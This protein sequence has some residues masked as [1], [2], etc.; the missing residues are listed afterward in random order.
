M[1]AFFSSRDLRNILR[2]LVAPLLISAFT[3]PASA[4]PT[5][6]PT[7]TVAGTVVSAVDNQ[8]LQHAS[9]ELLTTTDDRI[10]Q[11]TTSD[12]LGRFSFSAVAKGVFVLRGEAP[13]FLLTRYQQH[14][15]YSTGITTGSSVSTE[16]LTLKLQPLG[17]LSGTITDEN[18]EPVRNATVHLYRRTTVT[19]DAGFTP[20]AQLQTNDLG[21]Y[22]SA[23]L[24]PGT[25]FVAVI[26]R[27]WYAVHPAPA[28]PVPGFGGAGIVPY[29]D[30]ALDVAYPVTYYPAGTDPTA[31]APID[32][33]GN[34]ARADLQL[35][36][37]PALTLAVPRTASNSSAPVPQLQAGVFGHP[38]FTPFEVRS[39]SDSV[40]LMGVPPG[41]YTLRT[42]IPI[43]SGSAVQIQSSAATHL[44]L[45]PDGPNTLPTSLPS[46]AHIHVT[47]QAADGSP[48]PP[49][50][51]LRVVSSDV[52]DPTPGPFAPVRQAD[53]EA[54]PGNYYF[55][56]NMPR[57]VFVRSVLV[58]GKPLPS[59][60][61]HLAPGD[62]LT[63]TLLLT[64]STHVL[65]GVVRQ[66]AEPVS[67]AMLLLIPADNHLTLR[68]W[69]QAQSDLDGSFEI[70]S[71]PPGPYLLLALDEAAWSAHWRDP[72]FLSSHLPRASAVLV[73]DNSSGP[74][75]IP[76]P[77][78]LQPL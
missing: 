24:P 62:S 46:L 75:Q 35:T 22:Q 55:A 26:A 34:Q 31:A 58:S 54:A 61:I 49:N 64:L 10:L 74:I 9:V 1:H 51:Q 32:I 14:G 6:Q 53:L 60:D 36:P 12:E 11:S 40:V 5:T 76:Q 72:A 4:Q 25:Y 67:G 43:R 48:L 3:L 20:V 8:P 18:A 17:S 77:L 2:L 70:P 52:P 19:G 13:G 41:D 73:P 71:V 47:V 66:A 78:P 27:P 59:N 44:H 29:Q 45:T 28:G 68:T 37:V 69:F 21:L 65:R 33:H 7:H 42:N 57:R 30:P 50:L 39:S 38:V 56:L 23:P 16:F 63:C 15:A